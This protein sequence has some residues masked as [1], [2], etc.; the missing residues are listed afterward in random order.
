MQVLLDGHPVAIDRPSLALALQTASADAQRRGRII[1]EVKGDGVILTGEQLDPP[2]DGASTFT[3][4]AMISADPRVIVRQ[5]VLDA[6]EAL[7]AVQNQQLLAMEQVQSGAIPEALQTLQGAFVTWQAARDVVSRGSRLLGI[8]LSTLDLP[9]VEE[10]VTFKSAT[11][12][13]LAHLAALKNALTQQDWSALSDI[14]GYDLDAD[15]RTWHTLLTAFADYIKGMSA[16]YPEQ[17][18]E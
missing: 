2:S 3:Q 10:A 15:A 13:L 7:G 17:E 4:V 11:D 18:P 5:T 6:V 1:I 9:G 16:P 8:D 14:V 12:S